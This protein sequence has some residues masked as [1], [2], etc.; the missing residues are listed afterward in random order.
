MNVEVKKY[1]R[2]ISICIT[3]QAVPLAS[4]NKI[5]ALFTDFIVPLNN[6]EWG[7]ITVQIEY[8]SRL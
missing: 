2:A 3:M 4:V 7:E 5:A 1:G 8:L 6:F